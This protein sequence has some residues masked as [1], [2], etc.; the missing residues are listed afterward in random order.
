MPAT[1]YVT[2][3]GATCRD[4]CALPIR[5]KACMGPEH[6]IKRDLYPDRSARVGFLLRNNCLSGN[7]TNTQVPRTRCLRV[8]AQLDR[9]SVDTERV[10]CMTHNVL[11]HTH[12]GI[13]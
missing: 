7:V 2:D 4:P 1:R 10:N 11:V 9:A 8:R 12:G 3:L 5:C 13:M 6:N